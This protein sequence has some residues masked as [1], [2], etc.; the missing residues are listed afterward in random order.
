[1]G[2]RRWQSTDQAFLRIIAREYFRIIGEA[3]RKYAPHHLVFGDRFAFN[4]LDPE[5]LRKCYPMWTAS[6]SNR[7]FMA[8]SQGKVRRNSQTHPKAHPDL[9][10]RDPFQGWRK[11]HPQLEAGRRFR[12]RGQGLRRL[13]SRR[14]T[15]RIRGRRLWCN[16]VDTP[17]GFGKP[18]QNKGFRKGLVGRPGSISR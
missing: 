15:N 10:L 5:S 12:G 13:C 16:P 8:N 7:L 11:G 3:Q 9:R 4:T 6:R 14:P 18:G 17:K 2:W 1:M